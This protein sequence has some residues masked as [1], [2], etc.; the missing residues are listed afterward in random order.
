M[1]QS[2]GWLNSKVD[3]TVQIAWYVEVENIQSGFESYLQHEGMLW[4][5]LDICIFLVNLQRKEL[6]VRCLKR[7]RVCDTVLARGAIRHDSETILIDHDIEVTDGTSALISEFKFKEQ[8][9]LFITVVYCCVD[10]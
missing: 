5:I 10:L 9:F 6:D 1:G 3:Q 7:T 4:R 2:H 8:L